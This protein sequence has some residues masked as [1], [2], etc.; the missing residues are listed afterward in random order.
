MLEVAAIADLLLVPDLGLSKPEELEVAV[1]FLVPDLGLSKISASLAFE[2]RP[3]PLT[4]QV[5][6][7]T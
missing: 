5:L 1:F 3:I 7:T 6:T 2:I 4:Q